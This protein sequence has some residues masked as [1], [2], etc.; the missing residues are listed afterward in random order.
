MKH[1]QEPWYLEP[2]EGDYIEPLLPHHRAISSI[3]HGELALVVWQMDDD[4]LCGEKSPECEAN[5]HRIID[6]VNA[7]K[8]VDNEIL[9]KIASG[10]I[11][12]SEII[13]LAKAKNR[14][15]ELELLNTRLY[16]A[17]SDFVEVIECGDSIVIDGGLHNRAVELIDSIK[18]KGE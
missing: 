1:A 18:N 10:E 16:Y 12:G 7:C 14:I 13:E 6:C 17:L 15:T 8:G 3:D 5:A 11:D 4:V 2:F 9:K